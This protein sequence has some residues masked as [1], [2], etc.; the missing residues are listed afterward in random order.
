M[1]QKMEG[2][3]I[4]KLPVQIVQMKD[5]R[6]LYQGVCKQAVTAL[7]GIKQPAGLKARGPEPGV[8]LQVKG[9]D[10]GRSALPTDQHAGVPTMLAL[11]RAQATGH[12]GGATFAPVGVD[13]GD[14]SLFKR[15]VSHVKAILIE[16]TLRA[17]G[18]F[19]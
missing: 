7:K 13:M 19:P 3:W 10:T 1:R 6:V 8:F 14:G 5:L 2:E 11:N 18:F 9:M 17:V 12:F 4:K 15:C 16:S